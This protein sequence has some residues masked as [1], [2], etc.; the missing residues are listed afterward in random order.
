MLSIPYR[1]SILHGSS[2]AITGNREEITYDRMVTDTSHSSTLVAHGSLSVKI[3]ATRDEFASILVAEREFS[4][5]AEKQTVSEQSIG[6][7]R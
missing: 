4:A 5:D 6:Y 2:S 3:F 1:V 7:V